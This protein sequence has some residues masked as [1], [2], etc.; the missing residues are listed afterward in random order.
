MTWG[1]I[2]RPVQTPFLLENPKFQPNF[3]PVKQ[4]AMLEK[5]SDYLNQ[6]FGLT[7]GFTFLEL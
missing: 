4:L 5:F 2:P 1:G 3:P 7:G 6:L